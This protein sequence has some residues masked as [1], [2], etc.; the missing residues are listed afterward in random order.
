MAVYRENKE[1]RILS[2]IGIIL[3]A[4]GHLGYNILKWGSFFPII[5]FMSLSF[6]LCRDIFIKRSHETGSAAIWREMPYP[7]WALFCVEP[8]L[9]DCHGTA[10]QGGLLHWTAPVLKN[11]VPVAVS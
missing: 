1:F 5:L 4:A 7:A 2:A 11:H 10:A 3:V 6:C 9:W 8:F